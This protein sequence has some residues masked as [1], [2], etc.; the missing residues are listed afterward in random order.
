MLLAGAAI[1]ETPGSGVD[2]AFWTRDSGPT[3][4]FD[5]YIDVDLGSSPEAAPPSRNLTTAT[6]GP[7][8]RESTDPS[9]PL[10]LSVVVC[11]YNEERNIAHFLSAAL[12]SKGP[13]FLLQEVLVIASGCTDQTVEIAQR[14]ARTDPRVRVVLET[15]RR[16]K[17]AALLSGLTTASGDVLLVENADTVPAPDAFEHMLAAFADETVGLV[18]CRVSPVVDEPGVVGHVSRILWEVHD[19]V[20]LAEPKAGEA[21]AIRRMPFTLPD[22]IEDDDTFLGA[23]PSMLG[24]RSVYARKAVVFNRPPTV[25]GDLLRQRYR[26]NRQILNLRRKTGLTSSTWEAGPMVSGLTNYLKGHPRETPWV[27]ILALTEGLVR[28][29][30]M[31]TRPFTAR[32]LRVWTPIA[33]TKGG[34]LTGGAT[35]GDPFPQGR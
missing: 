29:A 34:I 35:H 9:R 26:V 11:A 18:C 27:A 16:G 12:A 6:G 10:R 30:A 25:L 8:G 19:Y 5:G 1:S 14:I 23:Y 24:Y 13:S 22:D 28:F 32:P 3:G 7:G 17:A 15:D 21:F 2:Q 20:S 33:S 4:P 31:M